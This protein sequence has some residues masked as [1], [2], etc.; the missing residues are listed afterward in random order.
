MGRQGSTTIELRPEDRE[1]IAKIRE[2]YNL[3]TDTKAIRYA[4][5][6]TAGEETPVQKAWRVLKR[7]TNDP[8]VALAALVELYGQTAVRQAEL[9]DWKQSRAD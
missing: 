8:D 4:L 3:P 5:A 2:V 7:I 9:E 1:R 6:L